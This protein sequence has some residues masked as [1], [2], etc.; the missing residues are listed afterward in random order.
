MYKIGLFSKM[1]KVTIKAL[2]YYD[3]VGLLKPSHVDGFSGYRYYS[4][5]QIPRL[6][7]ILMFKGIGFS[8]NEILKAMQEDINAD[9]MIDYLE[10]KEAAIL[11]IIN[12]EKIKLG[13]IQSYLKILKQEET[14]MNFNIIIKE[15]PEVIVASMRTV[16][17]N[18]DAFNTIYPEM[19]QYMIKQNMKC[20]VPPYCFTMY[21]DGE[22]KETNID[23]EICEAVTG[24]GKDSDRVKFKKVD[25][26]ET[27]ACV[28]HKGP[29]STIG[30]AY[31]AVTKWIEENG[32][33]ITGV[34]REFYIDGIWNKENPEEWLTE[35]QIPVK[36]KNL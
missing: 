22:Y 9:K 13:Q 7:R 28:M 20:A 21:H 36:L 18:Y 23:V 6:H 32:Y 27:A 1:N 25:A 30:M 31:G 33:A 16:I 4:A 8:I 29:Y 3:E 2:R 17:P 19:G 35:V 14:F 12:E 26:V 11:K 34:P 5:D 10:S 24:F 15:L